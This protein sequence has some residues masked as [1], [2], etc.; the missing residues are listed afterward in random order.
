[1]PQ[2]LVSHPF[3]N[4]NAYQVARG[5]QLNGCLASFATC[6]YAPWGTSFRS[7]QFLPKVNVQT[8][9]WREGIRMAL[10]HSRILSQTGRSAGMVDWVARAHDLWVSRQLTSHTNL[11]WGYEDFA[12]ST[13][14]RAKALTIK[15]IYDLPTV[16][17]LEVRRINQREVE[18][19]PSL[20]PFLSPSQ[21]PEHRL[22]RKQAELDLADVIVCAS[23]FVKN[24]LIERGLPVS[25]L[26]V[27]P[28]GAAVPTTLRPAAPRPSRALRLLYAGA[29]GPHKGIHH[30]FHA[31]R[32]LPERAVHLTLAGQWIPGFRNWIKRRFAVPF[33]DA[34]RLS[35]AGLSA[36]YRG[37]DV[38]LFPALR[39]GF[40]SVLVEAM[41]HG[42]PVIASTSCAAPDL[43][44]DG[45]EGLIVPPSNPVRL[46]EAIQTLL[47]R[48]Q[49][50]S[51]MSE[52]AGQ[53]SRRLS[54]ESYH[55]QVLGL[56]HETAP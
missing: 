10:A 29:I 4:P 31:L 56:S 8:R 45:V 44:R 48:P 26:R 21:E 17:H 25:R 5:L 27:L 33:H 39:D 51:A 34:G 53:L 18:S 7:D 23:S 20:A 46:R 15:T 37:A 32:G 47:D 38:L 50:I 11:I 41:A 54:W 36:E 52:A 55:Q 1:M 42:L 14:E 13:F 40:G 6:I 35:A 12:A 9:G 22:R 3:G 30:L 19:D 2:V 43:I 28:Y 16:H 49:L 24:S